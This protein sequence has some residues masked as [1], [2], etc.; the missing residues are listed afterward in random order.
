LEV[1]AV[2]AAEVGRRLR[3]SCMIVLDDITRRDNGRGLGKAKNLNLRHI[4]S[5]ADTVT[6]LVLVGVIVV[7]GISYYRNRLALYGFLPD[8]L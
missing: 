2:G 6:E 8:G 7:V 3:T 4:V 5:V 1:H